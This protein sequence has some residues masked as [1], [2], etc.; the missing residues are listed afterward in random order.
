MSE[1]K[2]ALPGME[3]EF[4]VHPEVQKA[5]DSYDKS[6]LAA[7]R[8]NADKRAD[9]KSLVEKMIEHEEPK[10]RVTTEDGNE[11]MLVLEK[12]DKIKVKKIEAKK[13]DE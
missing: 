8:A 9:K 10:V 2:Q 13:E 6:L 4:E 12:T 3:D 5:A 7:N 11:R 1:T